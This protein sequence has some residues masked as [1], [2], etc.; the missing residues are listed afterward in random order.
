VRACDVEHI[1]TMGWSEVIDG[2]RG[3]TTV[4]TE[5]ALNAFGS[6]PLLHVLQVSVE[7]QLPG[8]RSQVAWHA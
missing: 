4:D 3:V 8:R 2:P 6:E 1:R 7:R 5:W